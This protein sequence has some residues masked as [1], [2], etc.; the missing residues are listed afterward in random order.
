MQKILISNHSRQQKPSFIDTGVLRFLLVAVFCCFICQG[1]KPQTGYTISGFVN[2]SLNGERLL[3]A[4]VYDGFSKKGTVANEAGFFSINLPAGEVQLTVSYAGYRTYI[5]TFTLDA[6][7]RFNIDLSP[8][9]IEEIVI[10]SDHR[11]HSADGMRMEV[12]RLELLPVLMGE[13]DIIKSLQLQPGIQGASEGSVGLSIRGGSPDQNLILLDGL[14]VYNISHAYGFFS[15]FNSDALNDVT[16]YKS[17]FPARYGDRL[18]SVIDVRTREGNSRRLAGKFTL[19]TIASRFTLEGPLLG[20][21]TTFIISGRRSY[22]DLYGKSLLT[23]AFKYDDG[24]YY[25]YDLN[26]RVTHR[27]SDNNKLSFSFYTGSDVENYTVQTASTEKTR[28]RWGNQQANLTWNSVIG[29]KFFADVSS[30]Y[31]RYAVKSKTEFEM[32]SDLTSENLYFND[33][34][35]ITDLSLRANFQYYPASAHKVRFGASYISTVFEPENRSMRLFADSEKERKD[36]IVR[37]ASY[38]TGQLTLYVED[39]IRLSDAWRVN[40]GLRYSAYAAGGKTYHTLDPRLFI[41]WDIAT[42]IKWKSGYDMAHQ[43]IHLLPSAQADMALDLWVPSTDR[44][45]P[46]YSHQLS[47][48]ID[49]NPNNSYSFGLSAYYK[50]MKQMI[51]YK[52][53]ASYIA[54]K[55]EW[56]NSVEQSNGKSYG[57]E[58][59]AEKKT[60]SLTGQASYTLSKTDRQ[61]PNINEGV[62]YPYRYDRRHNFKI[63][64]NYRITSNWDIGAAWFFNSGNHLTVGVQKYSG[65]IYYQRNAYQTPNFHRLDVSVNYRRKKKQHSTVWSLDVYNAYNRKNVYNVLTTQYGN[66]LQEKR[67]FPVL[68][69]LSFRFEF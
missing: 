58:L 25:F 43:F 53:G 67:L 15:V 38:R 45:P 36:T 49:W 48:G 8:F 64:A 7:R 18:S 14:P 20:N 31:S 17:G 32:I 57:M 54:A 19:G 44:I 23:K 11:P 62:R 39:D 22:I 1:V 21:K 50:D 24:T 12:K 37:Q 3:Y 68:P 65:L 29:L 6:N 4:S 47:T 56:E 52:D 41:V 42:G 51:E 35:H 55:T 2:D 9:R 5:N 10:T 33:D 60:G 13:P 27:F 69:S 59:F 46:Q 40:A 34:S 66:D 63:A 26:T 28:N 61:S 16:V 30:G